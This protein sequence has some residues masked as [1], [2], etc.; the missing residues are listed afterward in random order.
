MLKKILIK[1]YKSLV[2]NH[3]VDI[4]RLTIIA[5]KNNVGKSA[6]LQAILD[7]AKYTDG[8]GLDTVDLSFEPLLANFHRKVN[9]NAMD[10]IITNV[11][12]IQI[13]DEVYMLEY[14][15][16]Y[17]EKSKSGFI[18]KFKFKSASSEDA[19]YLEMTKQNLKSRYKIKANKIL[20]PMFVKVKD[21]VEDLPEY[22]EGE[23]SVMFMGFVPLHTIFK[24]KDNPELDQWFEQD[25]EEDEIIFSLSFARKIVVYYTSVKYIGPLR[26]LPKE[27][28]L[29]DKRSSSISSN[30]EETIDVLDLLKNEE[31][32]Y[33]ASLEDTELTKKTL[34]E[35]VQYWISYFTNVVFELKEVTNNLLQVLVSGHPMNHSGFGISQLLPIIVQALLI[36][37]GGIIFL[38]QPEIHLHPELEMKLAE[39]MLCIIKNN[40]QIIAETHSE[41]IINRLTLVKMDY[42]EIDEFIKIYFYSKEDS[43]VKIENIVIDERGSIVNWPEG[44]FDQYLNFSNALMSRRAERAKKIQQQKSK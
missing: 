33:Y 15:F 2:M 5:G 25:E 29:L 20:T 1:N 44:F 10:N 17:D 41:H 28:Y 13:E 35:A 7:M 6:T 12:E 14:E 31:V 40:R 3:P 19:P 22:F 37:K 34:L 8:N 23:G 42:P 11:L 39:F 26:S 32:S 21:G 4:G 9:N 38:E 30:G 24:F 16:S 27:Y 18:S 36:P 43:E